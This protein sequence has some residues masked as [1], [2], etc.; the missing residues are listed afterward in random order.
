M[1]RYHR[2]R[3]EIPEANEELLSAWLW[4]AGCEGFTSERFREG[5]LVVEATFREDE[6][7]ESGALT[8]LSAW[9]PGVVVVDSG[10]VEER[11]WLEAWRRAAV[12]IPLGERLLVD[13]REWDEVVETLDPV[14]VGERFVLRL[15]ARTA[16]GVGSHES[17]RLA[18][19]LL[20]RTPLAGRRVLDVG[21]GTGILALAALE[22]GAAAAVG[23]DLD[24]AAALLAGQY[25]RANG[26]SVR[27]FAGRVAALAPA[28]RFDVVVANALPHELADEMRAI[29]EALVPGGALILSGILRSEADGVREAVCRLGVKERGHAAAEEWIAIGFTKVVSER[30]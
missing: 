13:P 26:S 1:A 25:A 14:A 8:E 5:G 15:P 9:V 11:D 3:L 20:E 17:T 6:R 27:C 7:P 2:L 30:S 22:L 10:P 21:C 19:E 16:F 12:P 24:P 28:A 23:F 4:A 29:A 18:Y